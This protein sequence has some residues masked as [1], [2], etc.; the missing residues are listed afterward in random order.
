[1][2][3][4]YF[5]LNSMQILNKTCITTAEKLKDSISGLFELSPSV[6]KEI[7]S[8]DSEGHRVSAEISNNIAAVSNMIAV[9][10]NKKASAISKKKPEISSPTP[11]KISSSSGV[12]E[13]LAVVE[14]YQNELDRINKENCTIRESNTKIDSYV[15]KCDTTLSKLRE[16]L[17]KLKQ[18]ES[19]QKKEILN[20]SAAAKEHL[21][22]TKEIEKSL[23]FVEKAMEKF[24]YCY[25]KTLEDAEAI[26]MMREIKVKPYYYAHKQFEIK[27]KKSTIPQNGRPTEESDSIPETECNDNPV[28]AYDEDGELLITSKDT[29][30]F[31]INLPNARNFKMPAANFHKLGGKSF[32]VKMKDNGYCLQISA[33]GRTI[34]DN[35]MMHW[36][37]EN[38]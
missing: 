24:S 13:Q 10:E 7:A 30:S 14:A 27:K 31:F 28:I 21:Y 4:A 5:N 6:N 19:L 23:S 36:K 26:V 17:K 25:N 29:E 11:P 22:G 3:D 1:M 38:D 12:N 33:D 9:A 35:G 18:L 32:A 20:A 34:D 8:F 37:K 16:I 2:Y 15:K